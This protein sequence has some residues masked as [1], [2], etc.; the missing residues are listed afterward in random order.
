MSKAKPTDA[1]IGVVSE[2]TLRDEDL[3]S[4]FAGELEYY[5]KRLHLSRGQRKR[6]AALISGT[7]HAP[8][9]NT[10]TARYGNRS[11]CRHCDLEIEYVG[12]WRDRGGNTACVQDQSELVS[13]L[14]DA[15]DEIAPPYCY[16]GTAEGDGACFGFWPSI[17]DSG[18]PRLAD[19]T[20]DHWGGDVL[21]VNDHGNVT[22]GHV[23][24]RG[25]FKAYWD[26]V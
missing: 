23:D 6:F 13:K 12:K 11:I 10:P 18:L 4:A 22:C 3:I 24:R 19:I 25:R 21:I 2:G 15:L 9:D 8:V 26:C 7:V 5:M 17:E 20:R 14:Q 16:F 1:S